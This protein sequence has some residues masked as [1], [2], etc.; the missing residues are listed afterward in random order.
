[1]KSRIHRGTSDAIH[2]VPVKQVGRRLDRRR[3]P[4]VDHLC[5]LLVAVVDEHEAAAAQPSGVQ[6][7]DAH[8]QHGGDGGVHGRPAPH[9]HVAADLGAAGVVRGDG[10]VLV[11][12]LL[13]RHFWVC[14]AARREG[15]GLGEMWKVA[16]GVLEKRV[17]SVCLWICLCRRWRRKWELWVVDWGDTPVEGWE[18][19][20]AMWRFVVLACMWYRVI[21][22]GWN[23]TW[24]ASGKVIVKIVDCRWVD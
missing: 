23:R 10:C 6:V 13:V 16:C 22:G 4:E 20:R 9:Q 19:E 11:R 3:F 5:V 1:M 18:R 8:A 14:H 21:V 15:G 24:Y 17:N 2:G 7:D 12:V